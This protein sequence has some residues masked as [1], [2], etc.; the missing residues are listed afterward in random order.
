MSTLKVGTIQDHQNSNTAI[1]IDSG[2]RLDYPAQPRF[3]VQLTSNTTVPNGHDQ[4]WSVSAA[5]WTEKFDVGGCFTSGLFTSPV[6][7]VYHITYQMYCNPSVGSYIGASF[8]GTA[9][10]DNFTT[11]S[12]G[13]L[14]HFQ[15]GGNDTGFSH[16]VL[17]NVAAGKTIQFG[18]YGNG[19]STARIDGTYIFGYK[20]G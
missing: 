18:T 8:S 11:L 20:I 16:S 6:A 5:S 15:A 9:I 19:S 12:G 1:S 4:D 14:W 7:G 13:N 17:V 2:G 10:D 3:L